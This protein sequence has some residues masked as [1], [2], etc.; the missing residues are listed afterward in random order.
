MEN[1]CW[2]DDLMNLARLFFSCT[3]LFTY[4]IE[5]LVTRSVIYQIMGNENNVSDLQ[6]LLIT[7]GIVG[8]TF[9]LSI[10]TDC[11]GVVLELNVS[12]SLGIFF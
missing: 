10:M 8:T 4:P 2:D 3:I 7:C 12:T 6:H 9:L 11:L 1:Y 5:C